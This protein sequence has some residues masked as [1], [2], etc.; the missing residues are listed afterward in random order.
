MNRAQR[1]KQSKA[2]SKQNVN[3]SI[4]QYLQMGLAHHTK[5]EFAAAEQIYRQILARH[6]DHIDALQLLGTIAI[7]FQ[8]YTEAKALMTR[9]LELKPDQ[10][11]VWYNLAR[12]HYLCRE[13][14]PSVEANTRAIALNPDHG[15]AYY[16]RG[17][18]YAELK[19]YEKSIA[20]YKQA[21]RIDPLHW[22]AARNMALTYKEMQDYDSCIAQFNAMLQ[23]F[24][25]D[26]QI[27]RALGLV[28][29]DIGDLSNAQMHLEKAAELAPGDAEIWYNLGLVKKYQ[30]QDRQ[31]IDQMEDLS[32]RP[33]CTP[34]DLT[35]FHFALAKAYEALKEYQ[36]AFAHYDEGNRLVRATLDYDTARVKTYFERIQS[37]FTPEFISKNSSSVPSVPTTTP[38]FILGMPRSGS[39]LVEQILSSHSEVTGAGEQ[40][41]LHYVVTGNPWEKRE[42]YLNVVGGMSSEQFRAFGDAYQMQ[43]KRFGNAAYLCDKMPRN[44]H[45]VGM[46]KL[47]LPHAKV[48]DCS[49]NPLD[50]CASIYKHLFFGHHPYA[51]DQKELAEHYLL[52][53]ELMRYWR[54]AVPGFVYSLRYEKLIENPESEIRSLLAFCGLQWQENC[55]KFHD[56]E[57]S[58]RTAS[59]VQVRQPLYKDAMQSWKRYADY[60]TPMSDVLKMGDHETL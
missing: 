38:I 46:I 52:Y 44:F 22:D 5:G 34:R 10:P 50:T 47:M 35:F 7:H 16:N 39:T 54:M 21:V 23:Q 9:S 29:R 20:D 3:L 42:D 18:V 33:S 40:D 55:L 51:Y 31:Q 30:P 32:K 43:M 12:A 60:I 28:M 37:I 41:D 6:P 4:A 36:P 13:M 56:S 59:A 48:I 2:Q 27:H 53:Q 26:A 57:R 25:N 8:H 58:V 1:R 19:E 17:N 45:F 49:R 11:N 24:P 14:L 15:E